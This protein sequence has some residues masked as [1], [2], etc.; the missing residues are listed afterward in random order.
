LSPFVSVIITNYNLGRFLLVA[1]NSILNQ[2]YKGQLEIILID[3]CSTDESQ[4]VIDEL[5]DSR[6]V[7]IFNEKNLGARKSIELGFLI[8]QGDFICRFDADDVWHECFISECLFV[9]R[10]NPQI[11]LVYTDVYFIDKSGNVSG[12]NG[13]NIKRPTSYGNVIDSELFYILRDYYICAPGLMA[14]REIWLKALPIPANLIAVDWYLSCSMLSKEKAFYIDKKLA[15]YR[16]HDKNMHIEVV[17]SGHEIDIFET[18]KDKFITGNENLSRRQKRYLN[19]QNYF[20]IAK[21]HYGVKQFRVSTKMLF[22]SMKYFNRMHFEFLFIK[23]SIK[24]FL[25]L[26]VNVK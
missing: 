26:L 15:F 16:V 10:N 7:K 9:F 17:I 3:D 20:E 11:A 14:K 6:I 23:F 2:D 8:A 25:K 5:N 4:S 19:S 1:V 24:T 18:I 22:A 13:P 12:E 21:K